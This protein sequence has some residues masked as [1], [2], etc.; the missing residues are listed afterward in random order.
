M[1]TCSTCV[2]WLS[3]GGQERAACALMNKDATGDGTPLPIVQ[4]PEN[5]MTGARAR[6]TTN[7]E[8]LT[9]AKFGCVMH[10]S[11]DAAADLI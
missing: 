8:V 2:A 9:P 11:A 3:H 7:V 10:R 5:S 4:V 1:E 6:R